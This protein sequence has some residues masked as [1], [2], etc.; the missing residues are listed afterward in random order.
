MRVV[1]DSNVFISAL[2][3]PRGV[4]GSLIRK[5]VEDDRTVFLISSESMDELRRVLTYPKIINLLKLS[6]GDVESFLSSIEMLAEEVDEVVPLPSSACRDPDDVKFMSIAVSGRADCLVTGD[7]D[8][9]V[10]GAIEE[11]PVMSPSQC[12]SQ[13]GGV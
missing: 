6:P 13:F 9:L 11:I 5:L 3:A 4:T 7:K 2:I 1:V 12:L 8:L 10:L